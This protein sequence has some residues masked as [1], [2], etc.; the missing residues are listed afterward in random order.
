MSS[1]ELTPR[2]QLSTDQD[3]PRRSNVVVFGSRTISDEMF[4]ILQE[5]VAARGGDPKTVHQF[6][7]RERNVDY[8]APAF[9]GIP[10]EEMRPDW[11]L[12]ADQ[13]TES[14]K[15]SEL[16]TTGDELGT[17]KTL[18]LGVL[19]FRQMRREWDAGET[20]NTPY[21][22]IEALCAE[23][24]VPLVFA[25]DIDPEQFREQIGGMFALSPAALPP[26]PEA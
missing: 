4:T 21:A 8:I 15:G 24:N 7:V 23:H 18:P 20:V 5:E 17:S 6:F 10:D 26:A 25:E 13:T 3:L 11:G 19:A 9:Y 14:N 22:E 12:P 2:N 16:I 1:K